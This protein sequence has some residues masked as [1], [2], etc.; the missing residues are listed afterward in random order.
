MAVPEGEESGVFSLVL[1]VL[2]AFTQGDSHQGAL[3]RSSYNLVTQNTSHTPS[4]RETSLLSCREKKAWCEKAHELSCSSLFNH[5][6][7][8]ILSLDKDSYVLAESWSYLT[9][10]KLMQHREEESSTAL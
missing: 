2:H 7:H 5:I 3:M 9:S 10:A 8:L 4:L 6:Q 1:P